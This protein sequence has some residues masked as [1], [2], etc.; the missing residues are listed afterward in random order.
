MIKEPE[1]AEGLVV[2]DIFVLNK[3]LLLSI[4]S[5]TLASSSESIFFLTKSPRTS[6]PSSVNN[7]NNLDCKSF[8]SKS[9][10]LHYRID[11]CGENVKAKWMG[12][13]DKSS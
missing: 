9:N 6:P 3:G 13:N 4:N 2:G 7:F 8:E 11:Q 12:C 10:W 5:L 1:A